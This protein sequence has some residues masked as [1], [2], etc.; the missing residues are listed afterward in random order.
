MYL[1]IETSQCM[2]CYFASII[3][4]IAGGFGI[5]NNG[6][7]FLSVVMMSGQQII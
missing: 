2:L 7:G 6:E 3:H 4:K 1:A 5:K